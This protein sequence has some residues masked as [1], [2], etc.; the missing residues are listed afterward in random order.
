MK[1]GNLNVV[2]LRRHLNEV[3]MDSHEF[4]I[5]A[6]NETRLDKEISDS[7]VRIDGYDIYKLEKVLAY[8]DREGKEMILLG[9][10][11]CDFTRRT[12]DQLID[13]NAKHMASIYELFSFRQLIDEPTRVTLETAT[14][15][16]HVATT[17]ARNIIKAGVHEVAL[18]DHF[19]IY[20]IRKFNG[21][22]EKDHKMIKT[23]SM[24]NFKRMDSC[25]MFL[26]YVGNECSNKLMI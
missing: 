8:L 5:L 1:I 16:D 4:D 2:S 3:V 6:L 14:I 11:N 18:S 21:A 20:C 10:T 7:E 24:K 9:D 26:V 15:I 19:M 12:G 25:L 13:N 17:C 23:R 22:V